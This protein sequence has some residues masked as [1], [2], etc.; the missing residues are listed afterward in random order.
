MDYA[1]HRPCALLKETIR[2][3]GNGAEKGLCTTEMM[4]EHNQILAS[5]LAFLI[6]LKLGAFPVKTWSDA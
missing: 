6:G 4:N 5:N 1:A 3:D 2:G